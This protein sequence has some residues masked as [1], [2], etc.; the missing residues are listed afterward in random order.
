MGRPQSGWRTLGVRD[1]IRVPRPAARM[2][3]AV[4]PV[5]AGGD[6][7]MRSGKGMGG[8]SGVSIEV[9]PGAF[10]GLPGRLHPTAASRA[11]SGSAARD[12][13][14]LDEAALRQRPDGERRAGRWW[15]RREPGIDAVDGTEVCD[16]GEIDRGL[17][18]VAPGAA[19][20]VENRGEVPESALGLRLDA[21]GHLAGR[22]VQTQL[23]GAEDEVG[24]GDSL[25]VRPYGRRGTRCRDRL[26]R[27]GRSSMSSLLVTDVGS[28]DAGPANEVAMIDGTACPGATSEPSSKPGRIAP[29]AT[30]AS[31]PEA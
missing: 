5:G 19:R 16:I 10:G 24:A 8:A 28:R 30:S 1:F 20:G 15:V 11:L 23:A 7:V 9:E 4:L 25:A 3:A 21:R 26:P 18:D 31:D 13:V 27:H 2:M 6:G 14:D 12:R 22:W 29:A 17:H